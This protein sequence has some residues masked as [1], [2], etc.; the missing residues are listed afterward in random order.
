M[1]L[2]VTKEGSPSLGESADVGPRAVGSQAFAQCVVFFM[3]AFPISYPHKQVVE[4]PLKSWNVIND[5]TV[6]PLKH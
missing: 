6:A 1:P 4:S 5:G 2:S 3:S